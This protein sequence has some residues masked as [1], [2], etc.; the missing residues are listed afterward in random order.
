VLL[1]AVVCGAVC[2]WDGFMFIYQFGYIFLTDSVRFW[3]EY[4]TQFEFD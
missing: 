3:V 4:E 2:L 1:F